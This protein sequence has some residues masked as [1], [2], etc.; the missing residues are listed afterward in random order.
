MIYRY[1]FDR[2]YRCRLFIKRNRIR[3]P[4]AGR[5]DLYGWNVFQ[6]INGS[7]SMTYTYRL[8]LKHMMPS[9]EQ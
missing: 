6:K 7:L 2:A 4:R 3:D 5:D 9:N 1:K 8:H